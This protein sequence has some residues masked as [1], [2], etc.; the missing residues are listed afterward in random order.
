MAPRRLDPHKSPREAIAWALA[1]LRE[2]SMKPPNAIAAETN[3]NMSTVSRV[4]ASQATV[5]A[6]AVGA[7]VRSCGQP[8]EE[9]VKLY[10][11]AKSVESAEETERFAVA[12]HALCNAALPPEHTQRLGGAQALVASWTVAD[13]GLPQGTV[14]PQP[15]QEHEQE[16]EQ[17]PPGTPVSTASVPSEPEDPS[18]E[19]GGTPSARKR[20]EGAAPAER[21]VPQ[22]A[23]LRGA[24]RRTVV[25]GGVISLALVAG[26]TVWA[27][28][29]QATG[30]DSRSPAA[31]A[32]G[33]SAAD[34]PGDASLERL[35][36]AQR[37]KGHPWTVGV[38]DNQPGLS[39]KKG[40]K[41]V[42]AEIE[43]AKVITK[44]LK[45]KGTPEFVA[46]GT[47]EREK[48]LDEGLV[49][50]FV[51]TYGISEER[52]RGTD[53]AHPA[54]LFAGPY[55]TTLQRIMLERFGETGDARI[56]GR[57]E[58]VYSD[59]DL[60]D[61]TRVCVV[62]GSSGEK[63]WKDKRPEVTTRSDYSLCIKD[64]PEGIDAVLS[65]SVILQE[66]KKAK[67]ADHLVISRDSFGDTEEYGIGLAKNS[68][69]LQREVCKAIEKTL[70]RRDEIFKHLSE[71]H[72]PGADELTACRSRP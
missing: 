28:Q 17:A 42:G 53:R 41:W 16:Q 33:S 31:A 50:M 38:K 69:G 39:E 30:D 51:G 43:Y 10:R 65:D 56:Q 35:R 48:Q 54:V 57:R 61:D 11:L 34:V 20:S 6:D 40:G 36:E 24:R 21:G 23:R 45:I 32:S 29:Y 72:L 59:S 15:E 60:P 55:F 44:A 62:K 2:A 14:Q 13:T 71:R 5:S 49:D 25:T 18:S 27:T 7:Y 66:Y 64:L 12:L 47:N 19:T 63:F 58:T 8:P 52:E 4:T 26:I 68:K 3:Y 22:R 1:R 70:D 46:M 67:R 37:G 9:W